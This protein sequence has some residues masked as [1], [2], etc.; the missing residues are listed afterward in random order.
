[1]ASG[2]SWWSLQKIEEDKKRRDEL[3]KAVDWRSIRGQHKCAVRETG[4]DE[5]TFECIKWKCK[6]SLR[7]VRMEEHGLFEITSCSGPDACKQRGNN[8][9][10]DEFDGEFLAYEVEGV[11]SEHPMLSVAELHK[12]WNEKF[13]SEQTF[14]TQLDMEGEEASDA[15]TLL[16]DAKKNAIKRLFGD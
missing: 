3:T 11:V 12:W 15:R 1:M 6:W 8:A 10:P 14:L 7:A 2:E 5:F 16:Q 9:C 13:G 4:K